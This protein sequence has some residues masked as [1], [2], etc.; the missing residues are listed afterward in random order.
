MKPLPVNMRRIPCL[1]VLLPCLLCG[2]EQTP[3]SRQLIIL[4]GLTMGTGY[5]VK[6]VA[7]NTTPGQEEIQDAIELLLEKINRDM[8]SYLPH[9]LLSQL[10]QNRTTDWQ[11]ITPALYTVIHQALKISL[12]SNGSFDITAGALVNLWGFGPGARPEHPPAAEDILAAKKHS[13]FHQLQLSHHPPLLRKDTMH[14]YLDLSGIAKGYAVDKI[15]EYL[16]GLN[17]N[18][19][20]VEIGGEI[21][22]AGNNQKNKSWRIGIEQA[23]SGQRRVQR[24]IQLK[25]MG[26]ASSGDYRNYYEQDG[27]RYSHIIDPLSGRP[28]THKLAA[29]T[30]LHESASMADGLATALLVMGLEAGYTLAERENLAALFIYKTDTG[31]QERFSPAFRPYLRPKAGWAHRSSVKSQ[32]VKLPVRLAV[33]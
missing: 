20:L 18:H 29:V 11:E 1:I 31:F 26:M 23:L 21:R 30:V 14:L 17:I 12:L 5:S 25:N 8:S 3:V 28:I 15:A 7:D 32:V 6:I 9:S 22:T 4:N 27:R 13:G 33:L 2:C 16:Q 24:I 19:Y 10:N